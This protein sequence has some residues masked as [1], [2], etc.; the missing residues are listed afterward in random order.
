MTWQR[1]EVTVAYGAAQSTAQSCRR[2]KLRSDF[3]PV[4]LKVNW[5]SIRTPGQVTFSL[6][7][8]S[9]VIY[10]VRAKAESIRKR[11]ARSSA[12]AE[13]PRDAPQIRKIALKGLQ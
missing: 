12:D 13:G 5:L 3:L 6:T 2:W 7:A 4:S 9:T 11:L 1:E 10:C 8:M